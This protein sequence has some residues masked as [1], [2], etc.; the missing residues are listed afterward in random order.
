MGSCM[1]LIFPPQHECNV[2]ALTFTFH[3]YMINAP[4]M[5]SSPARVTYMHA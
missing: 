3:V 4:R 1:P 5:E 2:Q